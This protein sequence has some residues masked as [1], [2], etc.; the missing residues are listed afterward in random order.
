MLRRHHCRVCGRV[1][2]W[3]C[4][5]NQAAGAQR[6]AWRG[7]EQR[8]TGGFEYGGTEEYWVCYRGMAPEGEGHNIGYAQEWPTTWPT[9]M[10][11]HGSAASS[12]SW[13]LRPPAR[14]ERARPAC[15]WLA[16]P[17]Q[18]ADSAPEHRSGCPLCCSTPNMAPTWCMSNGW[19][20]PCNLANV[21]W[22]GIAWGVI[23][24][25]GC[26]AQGGEADCGCCEVCKRCVDDLLTQRSQAA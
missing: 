22:G 26:A 5:G 2:C 9:R 4:S 17:C 13:A 7:T 1:F 20:S 21:A 11:R 24:C 23:A 19:M 8:E 10:A 15:R 12:T 6:G 16:M 14:S 25:I 3:T 18:G